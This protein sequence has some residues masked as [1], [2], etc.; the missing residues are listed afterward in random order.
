MALVLP[1][2]VRAFLE[3]P[4]YCVMA[5][6]NADGTPQLTTMWYDLT[7]DYLVLNMTRGL[8]K[9]RNVRRDPRMAIC[10]EDGMRYVT[11][12]GRAE[13]VEDR[14]L[15]ETEVNRMSVRY[16]GLR[17]G[18]GRWEVIKGSDRL[19]IHLHVERFHSHGL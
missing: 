3:A 18:S 2:P 11:L 19:G 10:V 12:S 1:D 7:D 6:I 8:L 13:I 17:L 16:L 4:H 5:T 15:Q 14:A 9:E